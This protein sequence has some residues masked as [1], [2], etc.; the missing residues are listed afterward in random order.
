ML[1]KIK[2]P[3]SAIQPAIESTFFA[4]GFGLLI[5]Y[6]LNVRVSGIGMNRIGFQI[7]MLMFKRSINMYLIP[8]LELVQVK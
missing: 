4:I 1:K 7:R 8:R 6:V 5:S 3:K 2:R